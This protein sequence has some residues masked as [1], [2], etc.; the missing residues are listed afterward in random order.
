MKLVSLSGHLEAGDAAKVYLEFDMNLFRD[1][2]E[3][4]LEEMFRSNARYVAEQV[5]QWI[6][7]RREGEISHQGAEAR[8]EGP[9]EGAASPEAIQPREIPSTKDEEQGA[10]DGLQEGRSEAPGAGPGEE[11]PS[12]SNPDY[13]RPPQNE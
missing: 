13:A 6:A 10:K 2:S 1:A 4:K 9:V 12:P 8:I 11:P 3:E 7:S 5:V